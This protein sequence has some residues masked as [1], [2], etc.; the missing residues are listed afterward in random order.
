MH[1]SIPEGELP[2]MRLSSHPPTSRLPVRIC[3][4]FA[5]CLAF[6][7]SRLMVPLEG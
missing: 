6:G 7:G 3:F 4:L 5:F 1:I 2:G